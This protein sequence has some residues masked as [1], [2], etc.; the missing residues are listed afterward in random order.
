MPLNLIRQTSFKPRCQILS[1]SRIFPKAVRK[2]K[3]DY[4]E[5]DVLV[6][7]AREDQLVDR[8]VNLSILGDMLIRP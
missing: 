8:W 5:R 4:L 3:E 7:N 6:E 2:L 1:E